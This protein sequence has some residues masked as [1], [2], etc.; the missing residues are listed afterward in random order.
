MQKP[1]I[2]KKNKLCITLALGDEEVDM[3][4]M[5]KKGYFSLWEGYFHLLC[6]DHKEIS[7]E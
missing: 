7:K 2:K 5:R 1:H 3:P 6:K 4:L